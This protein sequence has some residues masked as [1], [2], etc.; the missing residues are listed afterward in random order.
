MSKFKAMISGFNGVSKSHY[1]QWRKWGAHIPTHG[2]VFQV[3][4]ASELP[5]QLGVVLF[6][7]HFGLRVDVFPKTHEASLSVYLLCWAL[8]FSWFKREVI[9]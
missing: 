9:K 3:A 2:F 4:K 1:T 6:G 5:L 8:I 7:L